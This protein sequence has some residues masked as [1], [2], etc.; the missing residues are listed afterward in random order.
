MKMKSNMTWRIMVGAVLVIFGILALLQNF[1]GWS[2][3]GPL[4]GFF[5][6]ALFGVVGGGF[7]V[8]Y[9]QDRGHSWWAVIPGFSLLG[10][11]LLVLLGMLRVSPDEL[12]PAVFMGSIGASFWVIF[13]SDRTRWW[14]IIPGGA[15]VSL[16][17]LILFSNQGSWAAMILFGGLA[18]TFGLVALLAPA[19]RP[20]TWAWWPAGSLAVLSIIVSASLQP[21]QG[22]VW[23][24]AL[25]VAGLVMVGWS[26]FRRNA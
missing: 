21:L 25:I 18:A 3:E 17:L 19:D 9:L 5:V 11:A 10:L 13:F 4:W 23:P 26:F 12:L 7:V 22:W 6:A 20:R 8:S 2:L 1:A 15:L 16:A 14:A 24:L